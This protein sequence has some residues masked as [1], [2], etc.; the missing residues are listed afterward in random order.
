MVGHWQLQLKIWNG[1]KLD[2]SWSQNSSGS[3][4]SGPIVETISDGAN[5]PCLC[6]N[7]DPRCD[8]CNPS[9][10]AS[11]TPSPAITGFSSIA[12]GYNLSSDISNNKLNGTATDSD[13][14]GGV[15]PGKLS[16]IPTQEIQSPHWQ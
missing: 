9:K 16:T 1:P 3:G 11:F 15:A 6:K 13:A 14:L 5:D 4:Q 2:T 7:Y 8:C 12:P 10:D